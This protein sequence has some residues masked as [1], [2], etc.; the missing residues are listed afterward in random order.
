MQINPGVFFSL[1][2]LFGIVFS[3]GHF[4][5]WFFMWLF[6][7]VTA[8]FLGSAPLQPF[9]VYIFS[10]VVAFAAAGYCFEKHFKDLY[11]AFGFTLMKVGE[12]GGPTFSETLVREF[13]RSCSWFGILFFVL[14]IFGGAYLVA[15]G[16]VM[17]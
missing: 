12:K 8:V 9:F 1:F 2:I 11:S 17:F 6:I 13:M 4:R 10:F 15:G 16:K 14:T 3:F 5:S 7:I